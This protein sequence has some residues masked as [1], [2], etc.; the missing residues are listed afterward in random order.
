MS[1]S[2]KTK[3]YMTPVSGTVQNFFSK[4]TTFSEKKH[5]QSSN[6]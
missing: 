6:V 1:V 4:K 3:I 5:L 2:G